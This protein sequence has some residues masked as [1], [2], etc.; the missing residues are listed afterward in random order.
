MA[1]KNLMSTSRR[2]DRNVAVAGCRL[3]RLNEAMREVLADSPLRSA[4]ESLR[5]LPLTQIGENRQC[6]SSSLP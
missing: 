3:R 6:F 2:P 1:D 4:G 5:T